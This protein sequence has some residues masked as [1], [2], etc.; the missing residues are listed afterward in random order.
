MME[1]RIKEKLLVAVCSDRLR[2]RLCEIPV[3]KWITT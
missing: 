1:G 2:D 3:T